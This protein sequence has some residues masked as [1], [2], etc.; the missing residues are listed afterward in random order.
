MTMLPECRQTRQG[1]LQ[2]R[3]AC[4]R[5]PLGKPQELLERFNR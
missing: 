5:S 4:R 3:L 1:D 2:E